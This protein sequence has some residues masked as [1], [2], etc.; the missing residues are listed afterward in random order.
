MTEGTVTGSLPGNR[1]M[2]NQ[3]GPQ[4]TS[5]EE[6]Y[7]GGLR[8]SCTQC[9]ACCTGPPGAV[10]FTE[11]EGVAMARQVGLEPEI[12]LRR[13]AHRI[14][15]NWSLSERKSEHGFDCIFLDRTAVKGRAICSLYDARPLQCKTWPFW[16]ENIYNRRAWE[17]TKLA[18]P[19][20]GMDRG[21]LTRIEDIRSQRDAMR[22]ITSDL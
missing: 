1:S 15:G 14:D 18:T 21:R 16:P 8:F 9:G 10:W 19:C 22:G 7:A 11:E 6:W 5:D 17:A 4:T 12:F 13:Y 20:P 2:D 3:K